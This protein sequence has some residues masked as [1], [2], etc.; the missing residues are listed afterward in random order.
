MLRDPRA[1]RFATEFFGQWFGFYQ[2]DRYR[3]VDAERFPEFTVELQQSMYDEA[4]SFFEHIVREDRP[5]SDI[6]FA[7]YVFWNDALAQHYGQEAEA[8]GP[9]PVK[10]APHDSPGRGGVLGLGAVLTVT[11]APLRTSPV[12]RGDWIL[13]RVVG[14]PVPPPP[15]DVGS[16]P[17]DDLHA[18]GLTLRQRLEAHRAD[19]SC[20]NCHSRMDPLGFALEEFDAIGRKRAAYRDGQQIDTSGT[21]NDGTQIEGRQGLT[22]YLKSQ[23]TQLRTN[24]ATKLLGYALGRGELISDRLLIENMVAG[25]DSDERFSS[26]VTKIVT[27][28]QFRYQRGTDVIAASQATPTLPGEKT[29]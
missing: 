15:G 12:K 11:S 24:M 18:D 17:A 28:K 23:E 10:L 2:F 4:I 20:V 16:I 27:S 26:L 22:D 29:R 9:D 5:V 1:R 19:A 13:R 21:L 3:G 6:F 25:L 7:D 8:V 14:T